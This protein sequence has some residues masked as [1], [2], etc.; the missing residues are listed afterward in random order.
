M[1]EKGFEG[2]EKRC[3]EVNERFDRIEKLILVDHKQ[4]IERLEAQMKEL[5]ELLAVK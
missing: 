2:V 4:R 1:G 5:R 3:G